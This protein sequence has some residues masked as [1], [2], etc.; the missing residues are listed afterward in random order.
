MTAALQGPSGRIALGNAVLMIGR[1]ASH[2]LVVNDTRVSTYCAEIR[3][4]W[5]GYS[6]TDLGSPDGTFINDRRLEPK[7]PYSLTAGDRVL[8]GNTFFTYEVMP[9]TDADPYAPTVATGSSEYGHTGYGPQ[10]YMPPPPSDIQSPAAQYPP[11]PPYVQEPYPPTPSPVVARPRNLLRI[12]LIVVVVVVL[13]GGGTLVYLLTRPQPVISLTS[14]YHVGSTPADATT[15]MG[16]QVKGQKFSTNSAITFLLDGAPL[17]GNT[18]VQ[19]DSSGNIS[20]DLTVTDTW[21]VGSHTLTARDASNYTTQSGIAVVIVQPGEA[22]TPGPNGAPPNDKSFNLAITIQ[23][24]SV[25]TNQEFSSLQQ[26]IIITG[27]AD[28]AGGTVCR[29]MDNGQS[30]TYDGTLNGGS[31]SYHETYVET[32]SG[33]YKGGKLSYTQMVTSD[34]YSL[35]DGSTC[36]ANSS[37]PYEQLEGTFT[38]AKSISGNFNLGVITAP[39]SDGGTL[40][41]GAE[42][43]TWTGQ[44]Q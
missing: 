38:G 36:T 27:Q 43:G 22:D 34:Q 31:I 3:P 6:I 4:S 7:V 24:H 29:S 14:P 13:V 16:F 42:S 26:T 9:A 30:Q 32:C 19:S 10:S 28:P 41:V 8:I 40:R 37:Y 33:T 11:P 15:G 44:V 1:T 23:R 5:Q 18:T 21:S 2:Q 17:A 39:C 35:S 20:T 12:L 25:K